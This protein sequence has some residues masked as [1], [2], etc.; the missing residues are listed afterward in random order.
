[1]ATARPLRRGFSLVELLLVVAVLGILAAVAIPRL[2]P[3]VHEQLRA[4]AEIVAGDL[5]YGAGLAVANNSQYQF[6]F[7][8]LQNRYFLEHAGSNAALDE[9]PRTPFRSSDD[10]D[11]R[12]IFDL[13]ELPS[14]TTARRSI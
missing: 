12:H 3:G 6:T 11:D 7:Q 10:P 9:L 2:D 14:G 5:A 8:P 1:M 13:D 4:A